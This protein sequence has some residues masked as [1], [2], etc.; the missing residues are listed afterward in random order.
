MADQTLTI[1][2]N[3]QTTGLDNAVNSSS[4]V[5]DNLAASARAAQQLERSANN[6]GD[7]LR[8]AAAAGGGSRTAAAAKAAAAS[9][10]ENLEYGEMRGV[11]GATGAASRDFAKQARG[12]GGLVRLYATF[13]A[14]IFAVTAAFNVLRNAMDT[15]NM[16]AGL[17]LLGAES[18]RSLGTLSKQLVSATDGAISLRE[19]MQAT[20]M[21]SSAGMTNQQILKLGNVAKTASLALG[22]NMPDAINRLSRGIV[23]L[24]PELLDELGIFTKI[25][26]ATQA[27]ALQLGK[28]ANQLTDFERRQAFA[29]AVLKEGE[30]KY[31]ALEDAASNPY[32]KLLAG[33]K[34]VAFEG[35]ELLNK[36]LTPIV[37][38]LAESPGALAAG[39]AAVIGL[40]LRQAVPAITQ[41]R[42]GLAA[43]A[44]EALAAAKGKAGDVLKAR[45]QLNRLIERDVEASADKEL[46]VLEE[47]E[48]KLNGLKQQG[49]KFSKQ[50]TEALKK[51]ITDLTEQ[52]IK[53]AK[54]QAQR[55]ETRAN[56][57]S[58]PN[59]KAR[60]AA[61]METVKALEAHY[62]AEQNLTNVKIRNREEI[63]KT[64]QES[65]QYQ[66]LQSEVAALEQ[67][68]TK[69]AILSNMAYNTSLVGLGNAWKLMKDE[70]ESSNL[71]LNIFTSSMLTLRGIFAGLVG[72]ISTFGAAINKAFFIITTFIAIVEVL[73]SFFSKN[74]KQA[75]AF[76][77]AISNANSSVE[78]AKRTIENFNSKASLEKDSIKSINSM[79]TAFN[80]L[81]LSIETTIV[82]AQE[83]KKAMGGFDKKMDWLKDLIGFG[84]E[85]KLAKSL[86]EQLTAGL[87][88]AAKVGKSPEFTQ[89]FQAL[90]NVEDLYNADK[91][92]A[93]IRKL[94]DKGKKAF[95]D[96]IA[97]VNSSVQ[98][99]NSILQT[100]QSSTDKAA[101]TFQEF[102]QSTASKDPLFLFAEGLLNASFAMSELANAP[103]D[104][105]IRGLQD[106]TQNTQKLVLFSNGFADSIITLKDSF[107]SQKGYLNDNTLEIEKFNDSLRDTVTQTLR[108]AD[109]QTR[110]AQAK[111]KYEEVRTT[112]GEARTQ[113]AK[114]LF[115][116]QTAASNSI[117]QR[118]K[119]AAPMTGDLGLLNT[120]GSVGAGGNQAV[121]TLVDAI[122]QEVASLTARAQELGNRAIANAQTQAGITM[123]RA[124]SQVLTGP[125]AVAVETEAA[126]R[127]IQLR[128]DQVKVSL[129]LLNTQD[130]LT[131]AIESQTA[132]TL[133]NTEQLKPVGQRNE[134]IVKSTKSAGEAL[135]AFKDFSEQMSK[136]PA[137]DITKAGA[138]FAAQRNLSPE[139][140]TQFTQRV[141]NYSL[142]RQQQSATLI[143]LNAEMKAADFTGQVKSSAATLADK[144]ELEQIEVSI[145][146][147][148]L[149]RISL[150]QQMLGLT[151][152]DLITQET[153]L[154]Y[155]N[156]AIKNNQEIEEIERKIS[157]A[158]TA[159]LST[160]KAVATQGKAELDR[161]EKQVMPAT[162]RR[163]QAEATAIHEKQISKE[164]QLQIDEIRKRYEIEKSNQDLLNAKTEANL[165]I[166][167]AI[168]TSR[169]ELAAF[170]KS[171][172]AQRVYEFD[173]QKSSLDYEKSRFDI[174]QKY[175][176]ES[177]SFR[178]KEASTREILKQQG[179]SQI[180]IDKAITDERNRQTNLK[181]NELAKLDVE[182]QKR[183]ALLE[184][185][186][187]QTI[188]L[189][190]QRKAQE[191]LNR[192][193]DLE[194]AR[195]QGMLATTSF[196]ETFIAQLNYFK[197]LKDLDAQADLARIKL[198]DGY[199]KESARI[200]QQEIAIIESGDIPL[201]PGIERQALD[202][203]FATSMETL[204]ADLAASKEKA[205]ITQNTALYQA[206]FNEE[207][208]RSVNLADALKGAFNGVG[209]KIGDLILS[210]TQYTQTQE[211]NQKSLEEATNKRLQAELEVADLARAG[212][213]DTA[214]QNK[215]K[216]AKKE[217]E[218]IRNK[219]ILDDLAGQQKVA[220]NTKAMFKE[221]TAAYKAFYVIEKT[222]HGMRMA[223][224]AIQMATDIKAAITAIT[225]TSTQV[226]ADGTKATSGGM[227]AIVNAIKDLPFPLNIA[228][229]VATAAFVAG[230]IGKVLTGG[231][232]GGSAPSTF[233]PT[234]E[235]A[236]EVQGTAMGYDSQGNK[237]QIRSGVF[238]D[239]GAKSESIANSIDIIKDN[240]VRGLSYDNRV[241]DTLQSIDRGIGETA[242]NLYGI[243]GIITAIKA[244][245][246]SSSG[247]G[248]IFGKIF[249]GK[250]TSTTSVTNAGIILG[251]TLDSM[252][253]GLMQFTNYLT[254]WS[255]SG[256]WFSSGSSG[257]YTTTEWQKV[258]DPELTKYFTDL[259]RDITKLFTE[260]AI[261]TLGI[262]TP[263]QVQNTINTF[264][265]KE[266]QLST[267]GL[268]GEALQKE[269][270]SFMS[271][272]LDDLAEATF[273][274]I[275]TQ[276]RKFGEGSLETVVRVTDSFKK[277]N[278]V[279]K[280][281]NVM[282][283]EEYNP[284]YT[285]QRS[286]LFF[287]FGRNN[288]ITVTDNLAKFKVSERLIELAGSLQELINI[289]SGYES[290]FLTE[291]ERLVPVQ[292]AVTKEF[293]R[294]NLLYPGLQ[295]N[296]VRTKDEFKRLVSGLDITTEQGQELFISLMRVQSGFNDIVTA[297]EK[298]AAKVAELTENTLDYRNATTQLEKDLRKIRKTHTETIK[299]LQD[300]GIATQENINLL[301]E[302]NKFQLL[303]R[304]EQDVQKLYETRRNELNKTIDT[305]TQAKTKILD[306]RDS[307]L[308]G[309]QSTFTPV[310]KNVNLRTAYGT[311]LAQATSASPEERE[312]GR[313]KIVE[314]AQ[315]Y[316]QSSQEIYRSGQMYTMVYNKIISDLNTIYGDI[317]GE[318]QNAKTDRTLLEESVS[319]LDFIEQYTKSTAEQLTALLQ[320]YSATNTNP[321][322]STT[323]QARATGGLASG[324]TLVGE[325]GPELV[326]FRDPGRVYNANQT[327][328]M[329]GMEQT[330]QYNQQMLTELRS[331]NE[332]ID[333]L[334]QVVAEG[335]VLNANA[336]NKNTQQIVGAVVVNTNQTVEST[337]LQSR[338][339][340]K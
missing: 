117:Y 186:K 181:N 108:V 80:E 145:N 11:A 82:K 40:L 294:L 132:A 123:A 164:L 1:K 282:D 340:I 291:A 168:F 30:E 111:Q 336:T 210:F 240:S 220:A 24:E 189:E 283:L 251:D 195:L 239:T 47:K 73:D 91:V 52:E 31:K 116:A 18:G 199:K 288:I 317:E 255:R 97:G 316:L 134:T 270:S 128:I 311:L 56:T 66:K 148:Q 326:D 120:A 139:A 158:K 205:L 328:G 314:I 79:S 290:N 83:S 285:F 201:A 32:D 320:L 50:L 5:H 25:E 58:D 6:A 274:S 191:D 23:K 115:T 103:T 15:S 209:D 187:N 229:G 325:R 192:Q 178:A 235:Q 84:T 46:K 272:Y 126:K 42:A 286:G 310:Q 287:G 55:L 248:G 218:K 114:E 233:V 234:A 12:L 34:D 331:L 77:T 193:L 19:A 172:I 332:K 54:S 163:H 182:N 324:V 292:A 167:R 179:K 3:V 339:V 253:S 323:I 256:G 188:E 74:E 2:A 76:D 230:V 41:I 222:L 268:S 280:N 303:Q 150:V 7:A 122:K 101:K 273:S 217:E 136:N 64:V 14:N 244:P 112:P 297:Q 185:N 200:T 302:Y 89:K 68:A 304:I 241:L 17:N 141:S 88:L 20:A 69:K 86:T 175:S 146:Q 119:S 29:N 243:P 110:L 227:V 223:M 8:R 232:G 96:L 238:G 22:I 250:T 329:F 246:T 99:A 62:Q 152:R 261:D 105:I 263:E 257:S 221:K 319:H 206:K 307:L 48:A 330:T 259:K 305:L 180:D 212:L 137:Q 160:D 10:Q 130:R 125:R 228:A 216:A 224:A 289:T 59:F 306:L 275:V 298:A 196:S 36:V 207:M 63:T 315:Q 131:S 94:D 208:Q 37:K 184:I 271:A 106:L 57:S 51:D 140:L 219:S 333:C 262:V 237:V 190:K 295:I 153:K 129:D 157:L 198:V 213:D 35:L 16:I 245:V 39:L 121:L 28:A 293:N 4:Q 277:V 299:E 43:S 300:L 71:K 260:V 334:E 70:I 61:E 27:Y 166:E 133:A 265:A 322:L 338:I 143:G 225:S 109:A 335:A 98:K 284:S 38:I 147:Q 72:V 276:F 93:A 159:S 203:G 67:A 26:P 278:Q 281:L 144:R 170:D 267:L 104:D 169:A 269:L 21:A 118:Q 142:R 33:L 65:K 204:N 177:E 155:E 194:A 236:Q 279:L 173:L 197:Q 124:F 156:Q 138:E 171:Y 252:A 9:P 337:R 49:Y 149:S 313:S 202:Q 95:I 90:L 309:P 312:L 249:G 214:A 301:V 247:G 296:T 258:I 162:V 226:A 151:S 211:K 107:E 165:E 266:K 113:A 78:N 100:F 13:A 102:I 53:A 215:Y 154:E 321:G 242:K 85:D 318:I 75:K 60:A 174:L 254:T 161:L 183:N 308:R 87:N 81:A 176:Q 264:R 45:E 231:G 127:E 44:D 135:L 92:E 327:R